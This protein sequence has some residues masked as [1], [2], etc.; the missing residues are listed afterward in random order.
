[1][2]YD[3]DRFNTHVDD[4]FLCVICKMV[5]ENAVQSPQC[6]HSFCYECIKEWLLINSTCP[7][8]RHP[9]KCDDLKP[10]ARSLRNLLSK[11]EIKCDFGMYYIIR[12]YNNNKISKFLYHFVK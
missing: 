10:A 5:L 4:E 3:L 7:V 2:G 1:M 11:L 6:E 12:N 8:D 9:L